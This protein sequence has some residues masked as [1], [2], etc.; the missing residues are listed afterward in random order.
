MNN[1]LI[2]RKYL[3]N[4]TCGI[5]D[6][7]GNIHQVVLL[8]DIDNAPAV[9][10]SLLPAD[11]SKEESY[12]RGYEHGKAEGLLKAPTRQKGEWIPQGG[13]FSWV[14]KCSCCGWVDG[15]PLNERHKYCPNCGAEMKGEE[16]EQRFN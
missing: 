14:F 1:D 12:M 6:E 3:K 15:Y 5:I 11:E 4:L 2:S 10:F 13:G 9:K 8:A 16:N 7:E